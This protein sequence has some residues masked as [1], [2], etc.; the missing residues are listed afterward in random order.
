MSITGITKPFSP[1]WHLWGL[2]AD[3]GADGLTHVWQ[4]HGH[5]TMAL[6]ST[7]VFKTKGVAGQGL[8]LISGAHIG[9]EN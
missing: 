4:L 2:E 7:P 5:R 8:S 6:A 1:P 9:G 3:G